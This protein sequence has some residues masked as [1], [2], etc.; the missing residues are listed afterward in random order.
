MIHI[1]IPFKEGGLIDYDYLDYQIIK[2]ISNAHMEYKD[3]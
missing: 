1:G 2:Y 3:K